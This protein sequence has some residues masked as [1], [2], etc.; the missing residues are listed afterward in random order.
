MEVQVSDTPLRVF[1]ESFP[2]LPTQT[3][4][5]P[6]RI[7][8]AAATGLATGSAAYIGLLD[9]LGPRGHDISRSALL[10]G[11]ASGLATSLRS[12]RALC[13]DDQA[14]QRVTNIATGGFAGLGAGL[15]IAA[16]TGAALLSAVDMGFT[17]GLTAVGL[18]TGWFANR[19]GRR[20]TCPHC[21]SKS[22][23]SK[24]ICRVCHRIF[25]PSET[26]LDC[27]QRP[28]LNW[29]VVAS[30]LQSHGISYL[31]A[32]G[33]AREHLDHWGPIPSSAD[34]TVFK[35]STFLDWARN[36]V[37]EIVAYGGRARKDKR[38]DELEDYLDQ[39]G[40]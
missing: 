37:E 14:A 25:Y 23:C 34:G 39:R 24:R 15:G 40:F 6:D 8:R 12:L 29:Y 20:K 18:G 4:A 11:V 5:A 22:D 30:Y 35:C 26:V 17:L 33:L 16:L 13:D 2:R 9:V 36:H 21:G 19:R 7:T 3:P 10:F 31:D 38:D 32:E 1:P 27:G 28:V